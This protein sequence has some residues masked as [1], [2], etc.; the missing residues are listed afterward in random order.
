VT[1]ITW[2]PVLD[3]GARWVR[4]RARPPSVRGLFYYLVTE[5]LLSNAQS[6]YRRLSAMTGEGRRN[7][8]F[9]ELS[10]PR[11]LL[12]RTTFE[13]PDEAREVNR[14]RYRIDRT[15]GQAFTIVTA[16]EKT[17]LEDVLDEF[18]EEF[19]IKYVAF[20]G[21]PHESTLASIRRYVRKFD[22]PA[23]ML[24]AVDFDPT[25]DWIPEHLQRRMPELKVVRIALN[26]SQIEQFGLVENRIDPEATEKKLEQDPRAR[27]FREL[28]GSLMQYELDALDAV[29]PD[30]LRNLFRSAIDDLCDHDLYAEVLEQ[31][32]EERDEL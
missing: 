31:E 2:A 11:P 25:G 30:L 29:D 3:E 13:G 20:G 7:G 9:P 17:A 23:V 6:Y 18:D 10:G 1:R 24:C 32:D 26:Q 4:S 5:G 16:I 21:V 12:G 22:R 8:K 19:G 27:R 28:Y 15:E 14:N